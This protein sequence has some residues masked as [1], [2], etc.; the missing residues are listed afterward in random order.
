MLSQ[1][2]PC[3]DFD[4][5]VSE[6]SF[7]AFFL[8]SQAKQLI[9]SQASFICLPIYTIYF[10]FYETILFYGF[11]TCAKRK[12]LTFFTLRQPQ[13]FT[14]TSSVFNYFMSHLLLLIILVSI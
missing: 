5:L 7:I 4:Q 3:L 9:P 13:A 11:P 12:E 6:A 2:Q 14:I 10:F 1:A 8:A